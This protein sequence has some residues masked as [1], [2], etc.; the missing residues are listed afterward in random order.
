MG[1]VNPL[2]QPVRGQGVLLKRGVD[3]QRG[4]VLEVQEGGLLLLMVDEGRE[5]EVGWWEVFELPATLAAIPALTAACCLD[6]GEGR[7]W[8]GQ[9][10]QVLYATTVALTISTLLQDWSRLVSSRG[11]LRI[12][13]LVDPSKNLVQLSLWDSGPGAGSRGCCRGRFIYLITLSTG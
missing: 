10:V 7:E 2:H 13:G 4:S 9:A 1:R 6:T 8:G 5:E 12:S 3:W 11:S